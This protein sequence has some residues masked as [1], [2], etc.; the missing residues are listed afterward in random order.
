MAQKG[1]PGL[2]QQHVG[3]P[4]DTRWCS[5]FEGSARFHTSATPRASGPCAC[6]EASAAASVVSSSGVEPPRGE[7][8]A[9]AA[10]VTVRPRA[11]AAVSVSAP[12]L[13]DSPCLEL[14]T[15]LKMVPCH[16]K[17]EGVSAV[18]VRAR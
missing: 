14:L 13:S 3:L 11:A 12:A 4:C 8:E 7:L 18:C 17:Y 9:N 5:G 1:C 2:Q 6:T 16:E 15:P 10:P